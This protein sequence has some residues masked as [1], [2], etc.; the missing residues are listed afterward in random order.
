[1]A[2]DGELIVSQPEA[3]DLLRPLP[4]TG[5]LDFLTFR[6]GLVLGAHRR[7]KV[8]YRLLGSALG[9]F[10]DPRKFSAYRRAK[11][12]FD[13]I[14]L[15]FP[16]GLLHRWVAVESPVPS[17]ARRPGPAPEITFLGC[18]RVQTE[19]LSENHFQAAFS[20]LR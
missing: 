20:A 14:P 18:G 3:A 10:P 11:I 16:T 4:V 9:H 1:M 17:E 13:V 6:L 12:L 7:P 15:G 19:A 8:S 5:K 2:A